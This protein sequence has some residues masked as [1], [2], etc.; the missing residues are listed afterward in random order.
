MS[1]SRAKKIAESLRTQFGYDTEFGVTIAQIGPLDVLAMLGGQPR[2]IVVFRELQ[3]SELATLRTV[4]PV[5][6][7][8]EGDTIGEPE[9]TRTGRGRWLFAFGECRSLSDWAQHPRCLPGPM[10]SRIIPVI[11]SGQR[12]GT[13]NWTWNG[14]TDKPT[15]R[16][17]IL[18]KGRTEKGEQVCH[19][20]ITDGEAQ[21]LSDCSHEFAGQTLDLLEVD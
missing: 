6:I 4:A 13:P 8:Y 5:S 11:T 14:S 16:P 12:D 17:S 2:H 15:L 18:T 20:W 19:T 10:P 3:P 21:F 9:H 7:V 1:I